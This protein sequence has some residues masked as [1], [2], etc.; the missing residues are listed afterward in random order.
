M[1]CLASCKNNHIKSPFGDFR[2]SPHCLPSSLLSNIPEPLTIDHGNLQFRYSVESLSKVP[3]QGEDTSKES[4]LSL[5]LFI[6][7]PK[8]NI[9]HIAI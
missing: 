4:I 8:A 3:A 1:K 6:S 5:W 9:H 2:K 7:H